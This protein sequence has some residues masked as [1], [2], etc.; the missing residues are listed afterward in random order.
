MCIK[1]CNKQ[2][3][4]RE[5]AKKLPDAKPKETKKPCPLAPCPPCPKYDSVD[6]TKNAKDYNCAGL[7]LRTYTKVSNVST[8][9]AKLAS[10]TKLKNCSGNCQKCQVKFWLWEWNDWRL[11]FKDL[12]GKVHHKIKMPK[13]FHTVSDR[14]DEKGNGPKTVYSTNGK[15][16]LEGPNPPSHWRVKTG[17]EW[18]IN[19]PSNEPIYMRL[20]STEIAAIAGLSKSD[21]YPGSKIKSGI[22]LRGLASIDNSKHYLKC[23]VRID[24]EVQTCYCLDCT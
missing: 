15:R 20:E 17:D 11:E 8:Y 16:P 3:E 18:T 22:D 24:V 4:E 13:D 6:K 12:K 19:K 2:E 9:K 14:V 1:G 7:A 10:G 21:L 23:F 5:T